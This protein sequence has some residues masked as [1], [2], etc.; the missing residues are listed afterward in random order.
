MI[1]DW[2]DDVSFQ[3]LGSVA[4]AME[5]GYSKLLIYESLIANVNPL[6]RITASDISMMAIAWS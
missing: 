5:K 3:I 6:L 2:P 4:D 1:Q